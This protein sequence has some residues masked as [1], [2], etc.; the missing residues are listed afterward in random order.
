MIDDDLLTGFRDEVPPP[1]DE[2]MQ[3][4]YRRATTA[5][6]RWLPAAARRRTPPARL[7]AVA[8]A[9][10]VAAVV[11]LAAPWDRSSGSLSDLALAA[12]GSQPVLHVIGEAPTG[13]QL[14][15]IQSGASQPTMRQYE[16]WYDRARGLKHTI[17]RSGAVIVDDVLETPQG[18]YFPGGIVYDCAWIA[19]HP[20]EATKARVSCNASGKNGT[21]PRVVPRPKPTLDPGVAGFLDGYQQA[22]RNGSARADGKGQLDGH[23]VEWLEFKTDGGRERV[24]L[25]PATHKPLL[26][27]D[28]SGWSLRITTIETI[29]TDSANFAHPTEHEL[30]AQP[31]L[32]EA[33]DSQALALD[34]A[35]I[36]AAVP[37]ALWTGG[38]LSGLPLVAATRDDLKTSFVHN[39]PAPETGVGL[40]LEYGALAANGHLDFAH[41]FLQISE[42]PS[43]ALAVGYMWALLDADPATG[44]MYFQSMGGGRAYGLHGKLLPPSPRIA[45]GFTISNSRYITIQASTPELLLKAA[46]TLQPV[47]P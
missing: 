4:I 15:D 40:R 20:I 47:G 23:S 33:V 14:L 19:A 10:A 37:G 34:A 16:I 36:A 35:A 44:K 43:R 38:T 18:G 7:V 9:L 27:K 13:T 25:D 1:D 29:A 28:A 45:L 30:G 2:T 46:Q 17:T 6:P 3:R 42:A 5:P 24:A 11:A 26:V 21:T 12:I 8:A 22:L 31:T 39:A 41:P 32:G